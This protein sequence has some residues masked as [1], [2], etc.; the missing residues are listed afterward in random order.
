MSW[1][2]MLTMR[3]QNEAGA[4]GTAANTATTA[5]TPTAGRRR[6]DATTSV[7][8]MTA[9]PRNPPRDFVSTI[10]IIMTP[11]HSAATTRLGAGP[12]LNA[13]ASANGRNTTMFNARSFGLP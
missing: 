2:K 12:G 6:T 4:I 3:F 10:V 7:T 9:R 1:S 13:A 11:A 8:S 5:A